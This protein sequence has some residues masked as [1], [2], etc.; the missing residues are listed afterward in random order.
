VKIR[1]SQRTRCDWGLIT[2]CTSVQP[3]PIT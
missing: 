2:R 1:F 3:Y